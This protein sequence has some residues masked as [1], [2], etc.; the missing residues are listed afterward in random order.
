MSLLCT[1]GRSEESASQKLRLCAAVR[2]VR[3]ANSGML[4]SRTGNR[5]YESALGQGLPLFPGLALGQRSSES[6]LAACN[7]SG[8]GS[9]LFCQWVHWHAAVHGR[10]G[11]KNRKLPKFFPWTVISGSARPESPCQN[12]SATSFLLSA[13]SPR[14][15][16]L[17]G[18][19]AYT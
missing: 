9:S 8:P 15:G 16:G 2:Q 7:F 17:W 4:L 1:L 11:Q 14:I 10:R 6:W 18:I 19:T 5:R 13:E 3:L 12:F